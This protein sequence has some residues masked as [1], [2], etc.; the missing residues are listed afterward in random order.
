MIWSFRED[1][2]LWH[3]FS[4]FVAF[5]DISSPHFCP[6]SAGELRTR[7]FGLF[8]RA[9]TGNPDL[10][11]D[12]KRDVYSFAKKEDWQKTSSLSESAGDTGGKKSKEFDPSA[13][14]Q[15]CFFLFD[16][17]PAWISVLDG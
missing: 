8:S 12:D 1:L 9:F 7:L 17:I 14:C 11:V 5:T 15:D 16:P 10:E 2:G 13:L 4:R 3:S 6:S